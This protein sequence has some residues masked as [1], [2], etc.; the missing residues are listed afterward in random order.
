MDY[1][2]LKNKSKER[3]K[4]VLS[5]EKGLIEKTGQL[6]KKLSNFVI[7][8]FITTLDISNNRI[9]NT[10]S[11]TNKVNNPTP[12]NRFLKKQ[13][14]A[15]LFDY[16]TNEFGEITSRVFDYYNFFEPSEGTTQRIEARANERVSGFLNDLF[17]NNEIVKAIQKTLRS[18]IISDITVPSLKN[19]LKE[20]IEGKEMGKLGVVSAYHYQNG[21]NQFQSYSR[22]LDKEYSQF[23]KL[24]YAI[25]AAGE[26]KTT[27]TF[28][29]ERNG[30][31][32][33]REEIESWNNLEWEGKDNSAD[34]IINLGGFNC[35]HNLDW[36]SYQLAKRLN[37]NIE[38]SKYD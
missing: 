10:I 5:A 22:G 30:N 21:F 28:C 24:N 26:I 13:I 16:Y 20:Q 25:Y 33:T 36:I 35:R 3:T 4:Q 2:D 18:S 38:Q 27:R 34:V 11:N 32:Y 8:E 15:V 9:K 37:P 23:L 19:F 31:V 14:N 17:D 12:L 29:D 7:N 6:E 1:K